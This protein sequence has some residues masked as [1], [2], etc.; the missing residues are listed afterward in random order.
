MGKTFYWVFEG[1][2]GTGK[3]T[4]SKKFAERCNAV[5]T[6]EPNGESDELKYL[7]KMALN[8]NC[9]IMTEYAR[10]NI[11]MAIRS[12]HHDSFIKPLIANKS[13]IVS[14]RSFLSG[15]VYSRLKTFSFEQFFQMMD[16]SHLNTFPDIIIYCT[17]KNRKISKNED[18]IYDHADD[19]TFRKIDEG[20]LEAI[21]FIKTHKKTKHIK[22]ITFENNFNKKSEENLDSLINLLKYQ[23]IGGH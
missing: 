21:E 20:Y 13:T 2:E 15:M 6:Y 11:M 18:D 10:E 3:S 19:D 17:N 9:K 23:D 8:Q 12:M 7:R 1:N 4:L 22:I 5:W 16:L 14:D